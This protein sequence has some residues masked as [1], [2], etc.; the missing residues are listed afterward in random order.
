MYGMNSAAKKIMMDLISILEL[1]TYLKHQINSFQNP[2]TS[3]D[4]YLE[5]KYKIKERRYSFC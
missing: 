5:D 1:Q 2:L 3:P 4:G